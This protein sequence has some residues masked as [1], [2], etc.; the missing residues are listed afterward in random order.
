[1]STGGSTLLQLVFR[2]ECLEGRDPQAVRAAV[3]AALKLDERRA[4]HLFS[5]RRV[6]M[7]RAVDEAKA[8]RYIA[9]FALLGAR[10]HAE[11]SVPRPAPGRPTRP[12]RR[13]T[14]R[15]L[16]VRA[17]R[18]WR[19]AMWGL[20][21]GLRWAI[22]GALAGG[23]ALLLGLLLALLPGT[24]GAGDEAPTRAA[25]VA[26]TGAPVPAL[27]AAS[28]G[29]AAPTLAERPADMSPAAVQAYERSYA[30]AAGRK[31]FA[32]SGGGAYGWH[33]GAASDSEAAETAIARCMAAA[34]GH[35]SG[36]RL[37]EVDGQWLE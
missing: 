17:L 24:W 27:P 20:S 4:A 7:R 32:I 37:V 28:A 33:A 35:E 21:A 25:P 1:V 26:N 9:R 5:G 3:V 29:E 31:A 34:Q 19:D 36:C 10:L 23:G 22:V 16:R 6:V 18:L 2:G 12:A 14:L 11:P 30:P 13:P 8:H 15:R